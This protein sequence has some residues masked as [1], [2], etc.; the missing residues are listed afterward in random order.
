MATPTAYLLALPLPLLAVDDD[1][2]RV[3]APDTLVITK[4]EG[5]LEALGAGTFTLQ[6]IAGGVTTTVSITAAKTNTASAA[7]AIEVPANGVI[8]IGSTGIG[9]VP[10][11]GIC[12]I[13][14]RYSREG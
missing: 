12:T 14:Y 5:A 8:R 6:V 2:L 4:I 3:T 10:V 7:L 9:T 1:L 11:G 13:W